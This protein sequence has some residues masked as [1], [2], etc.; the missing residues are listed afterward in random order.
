MFKIL[1][2]I[3]VFVSTSYGKNLSCYRQTHYNHAT[4]VQKDYTRAESNM[5]P[6][7]EFSVSPSVIYF[8]LPSGN[9]ERFDFQKVVK[10]E[11]LYFSQNNFYLRHNLKYKEVWYWD[12]KTNGEQQ[13]VILICQ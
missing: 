1:L 11:R 5:F 6:P 4:G 10:G 12:L 8:D 3:L 9:K 2:F 7:F 13:T